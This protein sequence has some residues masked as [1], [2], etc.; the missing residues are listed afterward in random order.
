[1][2]QCCLWGERKV[3]LFQTPSKGPHQ[4]QPPFQRKRKNGEMKKRG[5]PQKEQENKGKKQEER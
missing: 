4:F 2:K 1:M 5:D 3:S